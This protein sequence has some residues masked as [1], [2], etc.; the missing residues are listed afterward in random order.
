MDQSDKRHIDFEKVASYLNGELSEAEKSNFEAEMEVNGALKTEVELSRA[1][2]KKIG[3]AKS[4][5][6][7]KAWA[8]LD[9]KIKA[10]Q[11]QKSSN[12]NP[13]ILRIAASLLLLATLSWYLLKPSANDT[14]SYTA[15]TIK[16][17]ELP[18]GS[19]I[20][21]NAGAT[22]AYNKDLNGTTREIVLNGEAFFDVEP[23]PEKPF[24]VNTA[25]GFITVLGTE[26]NVI[27]NKEGTLQ[28]AV[29]EG[30]VAVENILGQK[31]I[32]LAGE[33]AY[34][35]STNELIKS[36][37]VNDLF[38]INKTLRF[39]DTKL[40]L[41]FD[42]LEKNYSVNINVLNNTILDCTYSGTFKNAPID[43]VLHILNIEKDQLSIVKN[44]NSYEVNGSCN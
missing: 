27:S 41:V 32:L 21:A 5:N 12:S 17:I 31:V 25:G 42:I 26:F 6:T 9:S 8:Q 33:S 10:S 29:K 35:N 23:N 7:N 2:Y 19:I 28:V 11:S 13:W 18:D 30:K 4:F 3:T 40:E 36:A 16:N 44:N 24:V 38:W 43:T 34:L 37:D 22:I 39:R 1:L 15:S 20:T 14:I